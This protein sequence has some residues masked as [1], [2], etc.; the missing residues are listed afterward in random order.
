MTE[1]NAR[2]TAG[3]QVTWSE[4]HEAR[5]QKDLADAFRLAYRSRC[6]LDKYSLLTPCADAY[7][8]RLRE[9]MDEP[10]LYGV[11]RWERTYRRRQHG[12]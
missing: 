1:P 7:L 12:E 3:A 11:T 9:H 10:T 2:W 4:S 6:L 8:S 5:Y